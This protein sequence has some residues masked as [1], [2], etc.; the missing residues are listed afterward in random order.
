MKAVSLTTRVHVAEALVDRMFPATFYNLDYGTKSYGAGTTSL[1][2]IVI[3]NDTDPRTNTKNA[4]KSCIGD[5]NIYVG[6]GL[7]KE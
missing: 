4:V 3:A 1:G 2:D 7:Y 6:R 5:I